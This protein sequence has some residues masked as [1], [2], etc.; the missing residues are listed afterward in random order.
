[1]STKYQLNK[2]CGISNPV[3]AACALLALLLLLLPAISDAQAFRQVMLKHRD[4]ED[5][6]QVIEPLLPEGS[7]ISV[8]NN[9]VLVN[10]PPR[11]INSVV[12]AIKSLDKPRKNIEISVFRGKYPNK[13]GVVTFSTNTQVN[14]QQTIVTQEGR[15]VVMTERGLVKL[16]TSQAQYA[17]TLGADST[18]T[19]LPASDTAAAE[20]IIE[21]ALLALATADDE[22]NITTGALVLEG[23]GELAQGEVG[24][25][26]KYEW[27]EVPTGLYLR[28]TLMGNSR[29]NK[30]Q[31][32]IAVKAVTR[33]KRMS[34]S[35]SLNGSSDGRVDQPL[36]S[37]VETLTTLPLDEWTRIS[38]ADTVSHRPALGSNRRVYSTQTRDDHQQ[39]IWV[40]VSVL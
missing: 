30:P 31:A 8:D 11:I 1:M 16:P 17:N 29:S 9:S 32:R 37:T 6:K 10:T 26:E 22:D 19:T 25:S 7:A 23:T 36:S 24:R 18:S 15:T 5:I 13:K 4:A 20:I 12:K 33:D 2:R 38:Q 35:D 28:A 40:K 3:M 14:Q 39:A 34:G 21:D 27:V